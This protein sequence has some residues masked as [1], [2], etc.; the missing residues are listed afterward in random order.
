MRTIRGH[1]EL[2]D[3]RQAI[4][5]GAR[6]GFVPTMGALHEG[7]LSLIR[8]AKA[9]C[10]IA[11]VSIFVNPTQ[12]LPGEDFER[13]PRDPVGD[14]ALAASAGADLLWFGDAAEMYPVGFATR[15][16]L[17]RL[18]ER[19]CGLSRPGH[20]AGVAVVVLKLF[21]LFRP[22]RAYF[23]EKDWQQAAII[24]RLVLD[25]DLGLEV[26]R[27]AI[28][29]EP[30]GLALSSRN[31]ALS[32]RGR[33]LALALSRG[34]FAARDLARAG[35]REGPPLVLAALRALADPAI[36]VEYVELVD[37]ETLEPVE[38]VDPARG[39][40]LAVAAR[41]EG[42]RLIDNVAIGAEER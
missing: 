17:P 6:L 16:E 5:A 7:H 37:P 42:V 18:A 12:F 28:V 10:G 21:S 24:R 35:E 36:A 15:V 31:R 8:R 3:W 26:V 29:R 20:F 38:R 41:I 14:T 23:G 4:P 19:L 1:A 39:A 11:A 40:R 13:Y 32:P 30:G 22:H 33:A 9:E 34:L 27:C 2:R 25:L